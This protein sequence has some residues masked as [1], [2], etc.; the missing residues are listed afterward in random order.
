MGCSR[1]KAEEHVNNTVG[2]LSAKSRL[3]NILQKKLISQK[4]KLKEKIAKHSKEMD[5][6]PTFIDLKRHF[7]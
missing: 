2:M 4:W 5:R 7:N 1:P 3:Y 6:K